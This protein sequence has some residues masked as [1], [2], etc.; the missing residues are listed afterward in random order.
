MISEMIR[1]MA[2][3]YNNVH[4]SGESATDVYLTP[5]LYLA[6]RSETT[7]SGDLTHFAGLRIHVLRYWRGNFCG[8]GRAA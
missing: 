3:E 1:N 6:L 4:A 7:V 2:A 8:V 5:D